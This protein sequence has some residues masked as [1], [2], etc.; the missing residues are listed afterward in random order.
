M[1]LLSTA[2]EISIVITVITIFLNLMETAEEWVQ[3]RLQCKDKM[4][5]L[6]YFTLM[7]IPFINIYI[8]FQTGVIKS[9]LNRRL[10]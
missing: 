6:F 1:I 8:L 2:I 5:I 7:V 3:G 9:L 10:V 4:G